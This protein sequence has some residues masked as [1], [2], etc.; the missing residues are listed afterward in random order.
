MIAAKRLDPKISLAN[1][2][3]LQDLSIEIPKLAVLGWPICRER[4]MIRGCSR[5]PGTGRAAALPQ[6]TLVP[7][8]APTAA[9]GGSGMRRTRRPRGSA[10]GVFGLNL[11]SDFG[12]RSQ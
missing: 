5:N 7:L 2:P 11:P 3:R 8:R 1:T 4:H 9:S 10:M 12:Q 6:E